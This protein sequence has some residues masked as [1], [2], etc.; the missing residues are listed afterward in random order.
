MRQKY[1]DEMMQKNFRKS[2][3]PREIDVAFGTAEVIYERQ[4]QLEVKKFLEQREKEVEAEYAKHVRKGVEDEK[5]ENEEK[6]RKQ[7]EKNEE[8][9]RLCLKQSV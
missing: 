6:A 9:A 7:R 4:K 5:R 1:V 8:Y 2:G 3:C